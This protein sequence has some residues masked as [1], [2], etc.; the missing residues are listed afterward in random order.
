MKNRELGAVSV[1]ELAVA[2][3]LMTLVGSGVVLLVS[4]LS[5]ATNN[6]TGRTHELQQAQIVASQFQNMLVQAACNSAINSACST[7][8]VSGQADVIAYGNSSVLNYYVGT[9][10]YSAG[11]TATSHK[12]AFGLTAYDFIDGQ[13]ADSS[14][15]TYCGSVTGGTA[16]PTPVPTSGTYFAY[17]VTSL[18]FTY[19]DSNGSCANNTG[20]NSYS[21]IDGSDGDSIAS[22]S[23]NE[24]ATGGE[25]NNIVTV[26]LKLTIQESAT[27]PQ[28]TYQTCVYLPNSYASNICVPAAY[29][30]PLHGGNHASKPE[31]VGRIE[32]C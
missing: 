21:D 30:M 16:T 24:S 15:G 1:L 23:D 28:V 8:T 22:D 10:C 31:V 18:T 9:K 20:S 25:S 2:M 14:L 12:T 32:G 7:P 13:V 26:G 6:V 5:S 19:Y 3:A 27:A 17:D 4:N 29:V 11:L